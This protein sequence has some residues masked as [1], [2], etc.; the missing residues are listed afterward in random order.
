MKWRFPRR[1]PWSKQRDLRMLWTVAKDGRELSYLVGTA[2]F[3]P[4]SFRRA[5][6]KLVGEVD[7]VLFEGPL[8]ADSMNQIAAYG[9]QGQDCPDLG[10]LLEPAAIRHINRRLEQRLDHN[11]EA[12]LYYLSQPGR[13]MYFEMLTQGVRPWMAFFSIWSTG[14]GWEYSVDMEA[15]HVALRLKKPVHFLETVEEQ[16]RVLDGIPLERIVDQLN[17]VDGWPAYVRRYV[18]T[19]L[20]G[21]LDGWLALSGRFPSRCPVVVGERDCIL[22][23]RMLAAMQSRRVAAFVGAPHVPGVSHLLREHGY[24]VEHRPE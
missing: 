18:D 11:G 7:A 8:D 6:E 20:A 22:F 13:A 15:Y 4:Y 14:L 10:D 2:H 19:F 24:V 3:F 23:E 17:E 1:W 9:R 12:G 5:L 16:L 21:D